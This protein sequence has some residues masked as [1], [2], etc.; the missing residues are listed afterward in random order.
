MNGRVLR[1]ALLV[2]LLLVVCGIVN[3]AFREA[4][5]TPRVGPGLAHV[6]STAILCAAIVV[7]SWLFVRWL[8]VTDARVLLL[9]GAL[10]VVLT[11]AFEFGFGHYVMGHPWERLLADYNI[12]QGRIWVLVLLTELVGP[13]LVAR[14]ARAM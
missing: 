13:L 5:I 1:R 2:W 3:G 9:V 8:R 12:V 14:I 6:L 10:W 7:V 4:V 11:A